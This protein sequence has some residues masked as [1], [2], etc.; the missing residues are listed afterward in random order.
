MKAFNVILAVLI[1]LLAATSAIF[2][3][4]LFEKR[5]Q[6]V[7]A[8]ALMAEQF[9]TSTQKIDKNNDLALQDEINQSKLA[10]NNS[11]NLPI[12]MKNFDILSDKITANRNDLAKTLVEV[13]NVLEKT[14]YKEGDFAKLDKDD[15][16]DKDKV[17]T[18]LANLLQHTKEV[19]SRRDGV[20][21]LVGQAASD[22][23]IDAISSSDLKSAQY[24][25]KFQPILNDIA[26]KKARIQGLENDVKVLAANL[27]MSTP[28]LAEDFHNDIVKMQNQANKIVKDRDTNYKN[29]KSKEREAALHLQTIAAHENTIKNRDKEIQKLKSDLQQLYIAVGEKNMKRMPIEN[30]SRATLEML[31][32]Q[33]TVRVLAINEKFGFITISLGTN[34]RVTERFGNKDIKR[35]PKIPQIHHNGSQLEMIIARNMPS[36]KAEYIN[37]VKITKLDADCAIAEPC[38]KD[39]K[40]IAIGDIAYFSDKEIEKILKTRK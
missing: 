6:L 12:V 13:A 1:F 26:T 4:F 18:R 25:S 2:S 33:N 23:E 31:K 11:V 24:K 17:Q 40:E 21:E 29:W 20:L 16:A 7:D 36:G 14:G 3:F 15:T 35:D 27:E 28:A 19:I 22:L 32:L 30:G 10:H 34:T 5:K 37:R 9:E 8:H 39:G 38:D